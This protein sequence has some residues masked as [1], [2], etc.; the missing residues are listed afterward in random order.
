MFLFSLT[1]TCFKRFSH[2]HTHTCKY[3]IQVVKFL[4]PATCCAHGT[5]GLVFIRLLSDS[6]AVL[7]ALMP[8]L[9]ETMTGFVPPSVSKRKGPIDPHLVREPNLD[10]PSCTHA[11]THTHT[12]ARAHT[13]TA[14]MLLCSACLGSHLPP[15]LPI[16][17]RSVFPRHS[18]QAIVAPEILVGVVK[19][20]DSLA[21]S[22]NWR[23]CE[24]FLSTCCVQLHQWFASDHIYSQFVPVLVDVILEHVSICKHLWLCK[25]CH[26]SRLLPF[27]TVFF[28][29]FLLLFKRLFVLSSVF[30]PCYYCGRKLPQYKQWPC[31]YFWYFFTTIEGVCSEHTWRR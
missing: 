27:P 14:F 5:L 9:S 12:F 3:S 15:V 24:E 28:I 29:M 7:E 10:A 2:T 17:C 18:V 1:G 6:D 19:A 20:L 11:R 4:K 31:G 22:H 25:P 13:G 26:S 16:F 23:L 21:A 8:R 30:N